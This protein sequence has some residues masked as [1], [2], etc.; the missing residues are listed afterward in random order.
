MKKNTTL[1][2]I[3]AVL[4][5][6]VTAGALIFFW[7]N[8][9]KLTADPVPEDVYTEDMIAILQ[10]DEVDVEKAAS[11]AKVWESTFAQLVE[12]KKKENTDLA[13][14]DLNDAIEKAQQIVKKLQT[15]ATLIKGDEKTTI[16][17]VVLK[18]ENE[19]ESAKR[20]LG[21]A[22]AAAPATAPAAQAAPTPRPQNTVQEYPPGTTLYVKG[23][24]VRLRTGP[25]LN[26]GV[27]KQLNTGNKLSYNFSTEDWYCV[28]Y[29]G[30]NLY[31][32]K[33]F[34]TFDSS[35]AVSNNSSNTSDTYLTITGNGV[36]LRTGPGLGYDVYKQVNRGTKLR[37]VSTQ[38]D[39]YCVL[40]NN[41]YLYVSRDFATLSR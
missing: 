2:I 12:N 16:N 33:D 15:L 8:I 4:A 34:V 17:G 14:A 26:Y 38:G 11:Y 10:E 31:I 30:R 9:Q 28:N 24:G 20:Y 19:I 18:M 32:S 27:Y 21:N 22:P 36:R 40:Y 6:A 25:G 37:Y 13:K 7:P 1:Y 39:W 5:L 41:Y 23:I 35:E 3:I 29:N